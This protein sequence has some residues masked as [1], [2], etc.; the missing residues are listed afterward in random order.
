MNIESRM[1]SDYR[2]K[3]VI[4]LLPQPAW[5]EKGFS[6]SSMIATPSITLERGLIISILQMKRLRP[7]EGK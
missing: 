3:E 7:R 1:D 5:S 4:T 2:E 6:I